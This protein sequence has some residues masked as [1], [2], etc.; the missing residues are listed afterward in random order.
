MSFKKYRFIDMTSLII[1]GIITEAL[2]VYLSIR[3]IPYYNPFSIVALALISLAIT[4]YGVIGGFCIP[5]FALVNSLTYALTYEYGISSVDLTT[6]QYILRGIGCLIS[7]AS[8][9][10]LLIYYKDGTN[11][12]LSSIGKVFKLTAIVSAISVGIIFLTL[13]IEFAIAKNLTI[14]NIG[15]SLIYSIVYEGIGIIA[16]FLINGI[17]YKQGSFQNSYETF[18][19]IDREKK[20]EY[21]YYNVKDESDDESDEENNKSDKTSE[22]KGL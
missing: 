10:I 22:T 16:A 19:E 12:Y 14:S 4:R 11:L 3:A 8:P 21:E 9:L 17:L 18:V 1:L 20:N 13:S 15:Y 6:T 5:I 2:G 7:M